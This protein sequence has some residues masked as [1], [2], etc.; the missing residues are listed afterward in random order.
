[1]NLLKGAGVVVENSRLKATLYSTRRDLNNAQKK[2][3]ELGQVR[4]ERDL[5]K[6]KIQAMVNMQRA[7]RAGRAGLSMACASNLRDKKE[8]IRFKSYEAFPAADRPEEI[9]KNCDSS[10]VRKREVSDCRSRTWC[11]VHEFVC[12]Q[13]GSCRDG[14]KKKEKVA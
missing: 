11:M 2:V 8:S 9:C 4:V 3:D 1:M 7:V 6:C 12:G 5:L 14:F 10:E 13:H